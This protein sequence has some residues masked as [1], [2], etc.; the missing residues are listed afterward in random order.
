MKRRWSLAVASLILLIPQLLFAQ[1]T[2]IEFYGTVQSANATALVI[3]GQIIDIQ[4]AQVNTPL[5]AGTVVHVQANLE[6]DNSLV[7]R[8]IDAVAPGIIPGVVQIVGVIEEIN[9]TTVRVNGQQINIL[10]AQVVGQLNVGELVRVA[11][12]QTAPGQWTANFLAGFVIGGPISTPE[13][14]APVATPD[15]LPPLATPEVSAPISTPEVNAP[16][17]TP[18]AG[19]DFKISG[20]L[21]SFTDADLVVDGQRY[22]IGGA[23]V[24]GTLIVGTQ[25]QLEIR[26]VNGQWVLE[27]VEVA[28]GSDDNGPDDHGGSG[29]NS[30]DDHSGKGG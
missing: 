10:G 14:N 25:V 7:A 23:R 2:S 5:L 11:A 29:N 4:T 30:G 19:E 6:A 24:E 12:L 26:V 1:D 3:N 21:Q 13:V 22:F 27:E 9:G 17:S 28:N 16:A 8:Q 15:V 18:E 20:T